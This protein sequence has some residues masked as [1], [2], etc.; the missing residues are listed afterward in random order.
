M[1]IFWNSD[2]VDG[3]EKEKRNKW[4][5]DKRE[6]RIS[7][8]LATFQRATKILILGSDEKVDTSKR[9]ESKRNILILITK[10]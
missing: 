8:I 7:I 6:N 3:C 4:S 1:N 9:H 5:Q 2:S 10:K